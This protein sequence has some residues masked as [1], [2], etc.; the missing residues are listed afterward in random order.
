MK[1]ILSV[2]NTE[3]LYIYYYK[4]LNKIYKTETFLNYTF[5]SVEMPLSNL[6]RINNFTLI[7]QK[8]YVVI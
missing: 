1:E 7:I 3:L 6:M 2:Y 5:K 4:I 8:L